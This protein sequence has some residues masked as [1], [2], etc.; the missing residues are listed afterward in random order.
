MDPNSPL[1]VGA[2]R[3]AARSFTPILAVAGLVVAVIVALVLLATVASTIQVIAAL[4]LI[5]L[6][7]L[8]A[9]YLLASA[10][11]RE[12][13][14]P[15]VP[16]ETLRTDFETEGVTVSVPWQGKPV[17]VEKLPLGTLDEVRARQQED[18]QPGRLVMNFQ[19]VE[20]D[21]GSVLEDFDPPFELRVK[22][23]FEDEERAKQQGKPLQLAFWYDDRWNRFTSQKH[24]F[25][26]ES[27]AGVADISRWGDPKIGWGP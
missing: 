21:S 4:T 24:R 5:A 27:R 6:A 1:V 19:V 9:I 22:Y 7:V 16:P 14:A 12:G 11:A 26:F 13:V 3:L 25:R 18:F 20:A 15:G 23:T 17:R 2:R 8:L 10:S